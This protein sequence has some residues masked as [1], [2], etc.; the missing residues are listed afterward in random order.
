[1]AA[2]PKVNALR[3]VFIFLF[4][5]HTTYVVIGTLTKSQFTHLKTILLSYFTLNTS[6]K[7]NENMLAIVTS[8]TAYGS[9]E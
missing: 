5:V 9:N 6:L 8:H 7:D 4:V 3:Y 1:M 2:S